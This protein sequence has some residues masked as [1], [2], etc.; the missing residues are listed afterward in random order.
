MMTKEWATTSTG[1]GFSRP[2]K[3]PCPAYSIPASLCK[4]GG[5]LRKIEG[6]VCSKC[7]AMKGNYNFPDVRLALARRLKA[8]R[9]SDWVDAMVFLIEAE[10]NQYFRWHDAGDLQNGIHLEK[11]IQVC[12]RTPNVRHWLP[13][14]EAGIVQKFINNGG[15]IPDNLTIRLS[16]HMIDGAAP[17]ALAR[18]L[19]VQVSTVVT[20]GKTCP[21][22]EQGN[23]CLTCRACWDKK[24]EVVAYGKH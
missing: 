9:R 5:K 3:M 1:G 12:K 2:S 14:R 16:G 24:Q 4:T 18:R 22:G 20:S 10:G 21:A 8:L 15:R 19:G 23:K 7:Y 11:I 6:S 13:T 17:L